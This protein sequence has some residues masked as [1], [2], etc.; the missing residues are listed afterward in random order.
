MAASLST[1]V[2]PAGVEVALGVWSRR[3]IPS[4][5]P[6]S[7]Q[8]TFYGNVSTERWTYCVTTKVR[9]NK[10]VLSNGLLGLASG[11]TNQG[12]I[13]GV[14][15]KFTWFFPYDGSGSA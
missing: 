8:I 14:V 15:R 1:A 7:N 12:D 3:K 4:G 9:F 2:G 13:L 10:F 5:H 6:Q 11:K